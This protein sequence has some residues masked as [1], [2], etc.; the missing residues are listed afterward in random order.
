MEEEPM[1]TSP[2]SQCPHWGGKQLYARRVSTNGCMPIFGDCKFPGFA[3]LGVVLCAYDV[4][5]I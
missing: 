5:V 4:M 3:T 1:A 2:P